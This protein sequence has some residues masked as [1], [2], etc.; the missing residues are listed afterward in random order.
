MLLMG[1]Q[2][3]RKEQTVTIEKLR[4]ERDDSRSEATTMLIEA[5]SP[6]STNKRS[7]SRTSSAYKPRFTEPTFNGYSIAS[8]LTIKGQ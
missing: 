3:E 6:Y 1:L 7:T 4:K 5:P 2:N 8:R